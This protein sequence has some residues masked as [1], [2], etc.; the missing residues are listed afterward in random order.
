MRGSRSARLLAMAAVLIVGSIGA[1]SVV[2]NRI[3][4]DEGCTPGFWKNNTGAWQEYDPA[5]RLDSVFTIPAA[6][7]ELADDSLLAA[8]S[9]NGG[10]ATIDKAKLLLQHAV[11]AVL[12]A[13]S[14]DVGYPYRRF[15]PPLGIVAAVNAALAGGNPDTMLDL[16]DILDEA[17]NL[18]CPIAADESGGPKN[19]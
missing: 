13:A 4:D 15:G 11:A 10:P 2:A 1:G 3:G 16:K 14:E 5:S 6:L 17:N 7:S 9:F 18:G 19:K 12:N 8:L